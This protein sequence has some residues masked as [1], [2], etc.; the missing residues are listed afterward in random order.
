MLFVH[1]DHSLAN[2]ERV[3]IHELKEEPFILFNKEFS[4]HDLIINECE[5]KGG[6][7]PHVAYK[8]SQWDVIAELVS[9]ELGITLLP[10]S[11][12]SKMNPANIKTV[13]LATPPMWEL[14][15]MTKKD[16][17]LSYAVRSLLQ[18]LQ[19]EYNQTHGDKR[20]FN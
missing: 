19:Q 16:R 17:Y 10:K 12:Y 6:F 15:I 20:S 4:L 13:S 5:L 2:R 9:A 11:I 14:G 1:P 8:S 3:S 7:T 18:F